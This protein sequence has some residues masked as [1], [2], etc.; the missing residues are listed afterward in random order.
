MKKI[1]EPLAPF[2]VGEKVVPFGLMGWDYVGLAGVPDQ[3]NASR[4]YIK[5]MW[6][7]ELSALSNKKKP[8]RVLS[9]RTEVE[10]QR[11]WAARTQ[12]R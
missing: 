8:T 7:L 6:V 3:P 10:D 5:G 12:S 4:R 2:Q 9:I 11:W 1:D